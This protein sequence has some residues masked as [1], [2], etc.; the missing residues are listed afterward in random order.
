MD[1]KAGEV[2]TGN[3]EKLCHDGSSQA[4]EEV[5]QRGWAGSTLGGFQGAKGGQTLQQ[6]GLVSTVTRRMEYRTSSLN[7]SV[8]EQIYKIAGVSKTQSLPLGGWQEHHFYSVDTPD[9]SITLL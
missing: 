9:V 5:S 7:G 3:R 6:P 4:S 1:T 8:N 2:Q